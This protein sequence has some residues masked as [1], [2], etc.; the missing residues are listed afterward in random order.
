LL[1]YC[2]KRPPPGQPGAD[3]A[4]PAQRGVRRRNHHAYDERLRQVVNRANAA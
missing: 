4:D 2:Q 1:G 3:R